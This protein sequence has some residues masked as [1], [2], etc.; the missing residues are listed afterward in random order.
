MTNLIRHLEGDMDGDGIDDRTYINTLRLQK[1]KIITITGNTGSGVSTVTHKLADQLEYKR[2]NA[3]GLFRNIA[4]HRNM[5]VE[6]LNA[7]AKQNR[8]I[9]REIDT[10]LRTL[11]EG[12]EIVLDAR[13]GYYW[14]HDSFRVY[15]QVHPDIAAHR[16]FKEI[17]EGD[18]YEEGATTINQ[19][20]MKLQSEA[21]STQ[22][23][24]LRDYGV[25]ISNT[26][27]FDL[28]IDTDDKTP[29][30]IVALIRD[31]YREW[32]KS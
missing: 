29:D 30:E 7:Y 10:L 13:L 18:R 19:T 14:I 17:E 9:D 5:T 3:G 31:G 2:F 4:K 26:R 27:P 22:K 16:I 24:Y 32:L 21:E 20:I 11:G 15:L 6:E 1:K 25:D 8:V 28:I 12:D 23:R